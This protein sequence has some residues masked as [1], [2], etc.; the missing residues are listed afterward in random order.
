[1]TP[2][3]TPVDPS[4]TL[5][6]YD[7]RNPNFVNPNDVLAM[8]PDDTAARIASTNVDVIQATMLRSVQAQIVTLNSNLK[9]TYPNTFA[10][11]LFGWQNG[12]ITDKS[13]APSPPMTYEVGYF[14]DPSAPT[15][16]WAYPVIG[17]TPVCPQ[18]AI[19]DLPKPYAPPDSNT[20]PLGQ[21]GTKTNASAT[22]GFP[23]G[24]QATR[25]DGSVWQKCTARTP[26]GT[27]W[28]WEC[29]KGAN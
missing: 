21:L 23:I 25:E 24:Y 15:I 5:D 3:P 22:D 9:V 17:K 18:P 11:W 12:R 28:W 29:V 20:P 4:R 14:T 6:I 1:M 13:T 16:Q 2:N 27:A 8:H 7:P 19:P 26:F 10:A